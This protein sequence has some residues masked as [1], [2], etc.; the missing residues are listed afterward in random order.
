MK[1]VYLDVCAL[2]RPYDDQTMQ[3]LEEH[4]LLDKVLGLLM[5]SMGPVETTRFFAMCTPRR[6]DSVKRH[7]V[8]QG[9]LNKKDFFDKVFSDSK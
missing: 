8:W 1:K 2:C 6:M 5:R 3:I 7:Q 4:N 9:R